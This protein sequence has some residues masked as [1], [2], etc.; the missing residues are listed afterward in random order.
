MPRPAQLCRSLALYALPLAL[1]S[2]TAC[3]VSGD[4]PSAPDE[5][6]QAGGALSSVSSFGSNPGSLQMYLYVPSA[7]PSNAPIVVAMHGC[8][9]TASDYQNAGWNA[10]A[11]AKK[12][13]VV[14][15]Q[16]TAGTKCFDWYTDSDTKRGGGQALSIK[17]MV[18]YV[19]S[20]YSVDASRVYVTGLSA[21]GAMTEVMLATYPDVFAAGA[22][23]SGLPYGCA[24]SLNDATSCMNS[25]KNQSA[26]TWASAVTSAYAGYKGPWPRVSIW[27]GSSDY[28]VVEADATESVLQWTTVLGVSST[29]SATATVGKATHTLYQDAAGHA[30]VER[31][32]VSG[33]GHGTPVDPSHAC[34]TAGAFV[35]DVGLCSSSLAWSF[36][37]GSASSGGGGGSDAGTT[38]TGASDTGVIDTGTPDSGT[39]DTGTLDTGTTDTGTPDSG[40]TDTGTTDTGP[41]DTGSTWKCQA[42]T[43]TNV[44]H[45]TAGR[46]DRCGIGGSYVCARGSGKQFGLWN[47]MSSTLHESASGYFE[48]GACP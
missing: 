5:L 14:Y 7:M 45:V 19:K 20:T 35:L 18:D 33:M 10:L 12:F 39:T 42:F 27:H 6:S 40:T 36:F 25:A 48:P 4:D 32:S 13:Y 8:S 26:S 38:D 1:A 24:H 9:M 23:F 43:A 11:D 46:A 34:G 29:P 47:M 3:A 2:L 44:A 16:T 37:E 15:P 22:V 21:G 30:L 41:A 31:W 28:T 17:Q